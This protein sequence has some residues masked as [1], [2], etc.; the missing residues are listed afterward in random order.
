M[1]RYIARR[2]LQYLL[3]IFIAN[4]LTFLLPRF[5]KGDPIAEALRVKEAAAGAQNFDVQAFAQAYRERFGLDKPL[6]QQ[7]INYWVDVLRL[8]F[9]YSLYR[10][11]T[12]VMTMVMAAL[13]WTL[14]FMTIATLIA[15]VVG[16][17]LGALMAWP[18]SPR[19]LQG[20]V[21]VLMLVSAIPFY[22]VG[23]ALIW[24]FAVELGWFPAGRG[25][26]A[27]LIMGY[28]WKTAADIARHAILP[29]LSLAIAG[30]GAWALGMRAMTTSV[31]GEDYITFAQAKGLPNW[32]IFL[33]YGV[34]NAL[35][36]QVTGLAVQMGLIIGSG[37]LVETIFNYPGIGNLTFL[38]INTRDYFLINGTVFFMI[39]FS[40][41]ALFLV[42]LLYPLID[43]RIRYA[44]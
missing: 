35:L 16:S 19:A 38:A 41:T 18:S 6:W 26:S 30:V 7:F 23:L 27:T 20:V 13:P 31:L 4:S 11:P 3:I 21:P 17:A 14:G 10:F 43:P 28:N 9:G 36:P 34:R 33:N 12:T 1:A 42:D 5:I 32:Q 40:A 39:L 24:V 15:F 2:F 37:V 44:N 25:F 29:S 8:D 22:L